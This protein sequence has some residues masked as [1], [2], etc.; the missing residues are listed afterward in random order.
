M[1]GLWQIGRA[2][3][4]T[5]HYEEVS[6]NNRWQKVATSGWEE[7]VSAIWLVLCCLR[8]L[9]AFSHDGGQCPIPNDGRKLQLPI[10]LASANE[11]ERAVLAF[12][13]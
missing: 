12:F 10:H 4:T 11:G 6:S 5:V 9:A 2:S 13:F 1:I 8:Q 3:K 7:S